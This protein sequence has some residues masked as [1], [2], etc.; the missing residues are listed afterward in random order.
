MKIKTFWGNYYKDKDKFRE[1]ASN[2]FKCTTGKDACD[3]ESS[4]NGPTYLQ[5]QAHIQEG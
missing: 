3:E 4:F 5:D 2:C 1:N